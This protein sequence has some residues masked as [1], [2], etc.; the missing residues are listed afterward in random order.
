[1]SREQILRELDALANDPARDRLTEKF[2][3]C[4]ESRQVSELLGEA[5][6]LRRGFSQRETGSS[7]PAPASL[8]HPG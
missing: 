6:A 4:P 1:M 8:I 7:L 2:E 5:L 3:S